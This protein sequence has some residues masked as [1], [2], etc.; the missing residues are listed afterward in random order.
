MTE[1]YT[2]VVNKEP[3]VLE[4]TN[5]GGGDNIVDLLRDLVG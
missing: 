2:P 4:G 1:A 3:H 5:T